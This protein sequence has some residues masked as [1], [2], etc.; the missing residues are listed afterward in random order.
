MKKINEIQNY[1]NKNIYNSMNY[2]ICNFNLAKNTNLNNFENNNCIFNSNQ[3][4]DK[5]VFTNNDD[6]N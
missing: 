1:L 6:N 4:K 2:N 5:V 3:Y